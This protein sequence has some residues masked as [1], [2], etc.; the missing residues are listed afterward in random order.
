MYVVDVR[1]AMIPGCC[2]SVGGRLLRWTTQQ[3]SDRLSGWLAF[4]CLQLWGLHGRLQLCDLAR[5]FFFFENVAGALSF[6]KKKVRVEPDC[7]GEKQTH[8]PSEILEWIRSCRVL[9]A[10]IGSVLF[11]LVRTYV[12]CMRY[13]YVLI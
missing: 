6:V 8:R 9:R 3:C 7:L 1:A 5:S 12:R 13:T 10:D 2:C 4:A 11:S